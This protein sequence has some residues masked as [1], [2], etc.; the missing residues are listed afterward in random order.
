MYHRS[1]R[2]FSAWYVMQRYNFF[3]AVSYNPFVSYFEKEI[4]FS[5]TV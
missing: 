1:S 5:G 2:G 3:N 4:T